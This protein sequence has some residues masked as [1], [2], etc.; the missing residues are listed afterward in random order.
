[1]RHPTLP[2]SPASVFQVIILLPIYVMDKRYQFLQILLS[3]SSMQF[4]HK[5]LFFLL[6][7]LQDTHIP[8]IIQLLR[9]SAGKSKRVEWNTEVSGT[10]EKGS[11]AD[12]LEYKNKSCFLLLKKLN[13]RKT[14]PKGGDSLAQLP[15]E[16]LGSP[17]LRVL[18][19]CGDVALRDVIMWAWWGWAEVD[20][21]DLNGLFQP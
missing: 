10:T 3:I 11:R 19:K 8:K 16:V 17:S 15:R 14:S 9:W 7:P 1:M 21:G 12:V 5:S 2:N 13:Y 4:V 18:K 6:V 20:L